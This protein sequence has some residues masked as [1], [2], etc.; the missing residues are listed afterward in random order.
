VYTYRYIKPLNQG[1]T[2]SP[3][4]SVSY[5]FTILGREG[6]PKF[7]KDQSL[8]KKKKFEIYDLKFT[9]MTKNGEYNLK[10]SCFP[11]KRILFSC[12]L[13]VRKLIWFSEKTKL[14]VFLKV[15]KLISENTKF[16]NHCLTQNHEDD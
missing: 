9:K 6:G 15:R 11:K 16:S 8:K 13:K 2:V 10:Y 7:E 5:F 1:F 4:G 12:F 14:F 3:R